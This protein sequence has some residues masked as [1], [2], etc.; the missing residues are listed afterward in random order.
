MAGRRQEDGRLSEAFRI[1]YETAGVPQTQIAEAL[2]VDQ[3]TVSK[4]AR[5]ERPPP[6]WALPIVDA[7]CGKPKG[8]VLR[9]A[10]YVEDDVTVE[11]AIHSDPDLEA[12]DKGMLARFYRRMKAHPLGA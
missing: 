12:E 4:W 9:L 11:T 8:H 10:G 6:L 2:D 5:G 7:L 1:A 3:P